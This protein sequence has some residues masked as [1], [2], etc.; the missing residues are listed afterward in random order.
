MAFPS[1]E[2]DL[3]SA[4]NGAKWRWGREPGESMDRECRKP[5]EMGKPE[6][7][8]E[9]RN[10]ETTGGF[11]DGGICRSRQL[12]K[13]LFHAAAASCGIPAKGGSQVG[14]G[15]LKFW[16]SG[17]ARISP[18]QGSHCIPRAAKTPKSI[19][20]DERDETSELGA[21]GME[22]GDSCLK[23]KKN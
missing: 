17:R 13:G 7:Q 19:Q 6:F 16:G 4:K 9:G 23:K 1:L 10:G 22:A 3:W 15:T 18:E 21:G 5:L 8:G 20:G 2:W 12:E 14:R 11:W